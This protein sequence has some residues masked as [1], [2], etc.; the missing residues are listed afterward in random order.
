MF[1][2]PTGLIAPAVGWGA[3]A[4][5][6]GGGCA[7]AAAGVAAFGLGLY[8]ETFGC[9]PKPM[10]GVAKTP[11]PYSH[12]D[13]NKALNTSPGDDCN[14]LEWAI[15]VLRAMLTWRPT[16]L[17]PAEKGTVN[18]VNHQKRIKNIREKLQRLE[19]AYNDRCKDQCTTA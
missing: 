17:N 12:P 3:A 13:E 4:I 2:D 14:E 11:R 19:K 10:V 18:Y 7:A 5:C 1:N 9:G 16:D 6:E 8:C 15:K